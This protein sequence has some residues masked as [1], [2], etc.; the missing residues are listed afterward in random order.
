MKATRSL[1]KLLGETHTDL[2]IL[3]TRSRQ[4][5]RWTGIF[6]SYLD[7]E[8]AAHCYVSGID[9]ENLTIFVDSAAWAT[10]LR[11]QIPQLLPKLR[12]ANPVFVDVQNI[13]VK[14]LSQQS[15]EQSPSLGQTG[16]T[17]NMDNA[18]S[19]NSL[20]N[21]IDDPEL[22]L[23]LQRLAKHGRQN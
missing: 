7:A 22:Q 8:L 14:I 10:R 13:R 21:S 2:A 11:F 20:S 3:V 19:I 16:P 1:N 4:L 17:M 12:H 5:Q 9:A 18:K 6:R 23:A 15:I